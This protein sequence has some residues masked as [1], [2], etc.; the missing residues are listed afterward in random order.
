MEKNAKL[1]KYQAA[2]HNHLALIEFENSVIKTMEYL[3][4]PQIED[5][6]SD[7]RMAI[8]NE[9]VSTL[10]HEVKTECQKFRQ[11]LTV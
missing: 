5:G 7:I 4:D 6:I 1:A 9:I 3:A 2:I 11:M 10:R 8:K